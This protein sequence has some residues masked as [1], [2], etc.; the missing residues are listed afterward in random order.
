ME[1]RALQTKLEVR[2]IGQEEAGEQRRVLTGVVRYN[3]QSENFYSERDG[4]AWYE[5]LAPSAFTESL[6]NRDVL[7]LWSHDT[8]QVLGNTKNGTLRLD[9]RAD[10]LYFEID[11]PNTTLGNDVR[12]MVSRG[13]VDG[14]SFG[15]TIEGDTVERMNQEGGKTVYNRTV[16]TAT[17]YEISPV[18]F[19]AYPQNSV[20]ARSILDAKEQKQRHETHIRLELDLV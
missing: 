13:D 4:V 12:E 18:A 19:P 10:G 11:L 5:Y 2:Q 15:M 16:T 14:V 7:A 20:A 17:L 9:N 1:H 3:T 6:Q 8:A